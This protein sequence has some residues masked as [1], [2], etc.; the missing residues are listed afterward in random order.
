LLFFTVKGF[1]FYPIQQRKS[2]GFGSSDSDNNKPIKR[3]KSDHY[4]PKDAK[5]KNL[6]FDEYYLSTN[7]PNSIRNQKL[8]EMIQ[9]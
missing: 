3:V 4:L 7:N 9:E 2:T 5:K 8:K 1:S 6:H